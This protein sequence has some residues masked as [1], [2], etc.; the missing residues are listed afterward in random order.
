MRGSSTNGLPKC[1]YFV[2]TTFR[3]IGP[4]SK[5][6]TLV[7]IKQRGN[8]IKYELINGNYILVLEKSGE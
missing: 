3:F 6:P 5:K 4:Y 1:I 7:A 8:I 2:E